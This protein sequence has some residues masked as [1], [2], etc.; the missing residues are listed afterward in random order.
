MSSRH[1]VLNKDDNTVTIKMAVPD[2]IRLVT[3]IRRYTSILQSARAHYQKKAKKDPST[4]RNRNRS[5]LT[6]IFHLLDIPP[7][8]RHSIDINLCDYEPIAPP[9][10]P[11][12]KIE[13]PKSI[14]KTP[15]TKSL[16]VKHKVKFAG[17]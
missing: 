3:A 17:V 1:E 2:Y 10:Y 16:R 5:S 9:S 4:V 7:P 11:P 12:E 8:F 14:L 13:V 6:T 15:S